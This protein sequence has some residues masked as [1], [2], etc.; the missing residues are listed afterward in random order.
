[1]FF[2]HLLLLAI[3]RSSFT[4]RQAMFPVVLALCFILKIIWYPEPYVPKF[5]HYGTCTK[6]TLQALERRVLKIERRN[7]NIEILWFC[8][9]YKLS[10]KFTSFNL[11]NQN[12]HLL[13]QVHTLGKKLQI[14]EYKDH[15][16]VS[17]LGKR[18]MMIWV[19]SYLIALVE[20]QLFVCTNLLKT[21][22][23]MVKFV[24]TASNKS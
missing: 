24:I 17:V 6:I 16:K 10:P 20:C 4:K 15:K 7:V 2:R 9:I 18:N 21:S 13:S 19:N 5:T 11:Y 12:R 22:S 14:A 1:M 3:L 23:E 8:L